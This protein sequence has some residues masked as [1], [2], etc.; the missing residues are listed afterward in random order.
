MV[1]PA[2]RKLSS[3]G[4]RRCP[5]DVEG[6]VGV[7]LYSE[8]NQGATVSGS[9]H[10]RIDPEIAGTSWIPGRNRG[11]RQAPSA[12]RKLPTGWLARGGPLRSSTGKPRQRP[13]PSESR[14]PSVH[15]S[16]TVNGRLLRA[17]ARVQ[18]SGR[19][20]GKS[21][22]VLR[23]VRDLQ[24]GRGFSSRGRRP[25]SGWRV[26]RKGQSIFLVILV[27]TGTEEEPVAPEPRAQARVR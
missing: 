19:R 2:D 12:P 15:R 13:R 20:K 5:S 17:Q 24:Q 25:G 14:E 10:A 8:S 26:G 23:K 21:R 1:A 3:Q 9:F 27:P 4:S 22:G 18:V 6:G 16:V 11:F 7:A